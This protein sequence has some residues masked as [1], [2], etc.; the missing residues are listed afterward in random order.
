[1]TAQPVCAFVASSFDD[2]MVRP[3]SFQMASSSTSGGHQE[4]DAFAAAQTI[5]P[6]GLGSKG[7]LPGGSLPGGSLPGGSLP[8][9]AR[10]F[11]SRRRT[12]RWTW[13]AI[14]IALMVACSSGCSTAR[15]LSARS[16]RENPLA[17]QLRLMTRQGPQ[18]SERTWNTLRRYGLREGYDN[19]AHICLQKIQDTLRENR[20]P[21][22]IHALAELSY[23]EGKK[24][25]AVGR[26]SDAL[27]HFGVTRPTAMTICSR[28]SFPRHAIG[29]TP[30]FEPLAICTTSL[31]KTRCDCFAKNITSSP[32][33]PIG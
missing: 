29:M 10:R 8:T 13:P 14:W 30:S 25:E 15:Y 7:S 28:K 6:L 27:G 17:A 16:V 12:P 5:S 26:A 20:D 9:G 1:M 11:G 33:K 19:D 3:L 24:A 4:I 22:L 32:A 18:I 23:V 31:W 2:R 21:E